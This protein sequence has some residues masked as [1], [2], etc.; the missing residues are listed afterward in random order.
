MNVSSVYVTVCSATIVQSFQEVSLKPAGSLRAVPESLRA[1]I[2]TG[3][4][5]RARW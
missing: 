2:V 3:P 5:A 4:A 1:P